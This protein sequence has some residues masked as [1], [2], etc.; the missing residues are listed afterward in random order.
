MRMHS[1]TLFILDR[2]G[3]RLLLLTSTDGV[4]VCLL[5]LASALH[6]RSIGSPPG[7]GQPATPL[8]GG[9][10]VRASSFSIGMAHMG[11][12]HGR[13]PVNQSMAAAS[14]SP[15]DLAILQS[16]REQNVKALQLVHKTTTSRRRHASS[17]KKRFR[18][19]FLDV[20]VVMELS[21]A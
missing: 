13:L 17:E 1:K 15:F 6:A 18:Q 7:S 3:R 19:P 20:L 21:N 10:D 8:A 11:N 16:G 9:A 12:N 2:V 14:R 5:T 4:V